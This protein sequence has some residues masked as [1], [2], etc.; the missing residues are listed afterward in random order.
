MKQCRQCNLAF[1]SVNE[2]GLCA[3]CAPAQ[4]QQPPSQ[5]DGELERMRAQLA[6]SDQRFQMLEASVRQAQQPQQQQLSPEEQRRQ[7]NQQAWANPAEFTHN[8][9]AQVA[10]QAVNQAL[11]ADHET[12]V[13][14]ARD[15]AKEQLDDEMR[16]YFDKYLPEIIQRLNGMQPQFHRNVSVWLNNAQMVIAAHFREI[17]HDQKEAA[18]AASG[19][20]QAPAIRVNDGPAAPSPRAPGASGKR[21]EELPDEAKR[22]ARKLGI[23]ED[24]MREGIKAFENQNEGDSDKPSSWDPYISFNRETGHV[25]RRRQ[26]Q[27]QRVS[28]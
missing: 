11:A 27:Q 24:R 9:A 10:N 1:D 8:V 22:I 21:V 13:I 4:Q 7:A 6:Q 15:K 2:Q 5:R 25:A 14:V 16:P 28:A 23:S 17:M 3:T 12:M 26:A 18:Q 20:Q 19:R